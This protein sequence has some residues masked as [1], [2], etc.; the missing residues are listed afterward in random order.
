MAPRKYSAK[1]RLRGVFP[2]ARVVRGPDWMWGDKDGQAEGRVTEVEDW[3]SNSFRSAVE[4]RWNTSGDT[5]IYRM[6]HEGKVST[7]LAFLM[8]IIIRQYQD[9]CVCCVIYFTVLSNKS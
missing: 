3:G 5:I 4:V 8:E 1:V 9:S 7:A 6:G 2:G